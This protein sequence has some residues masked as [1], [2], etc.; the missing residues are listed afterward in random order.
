MSHIEE[1]RSLGRPQM[2]ERAASLFQKQ[3]EKGLGEFDNALHAGDAAE[4][5]RAAHALKSAALS[6]GGRRFAAVAGDC[7]QAARK[8]NLET[9]G[10]LATRL[11]P[12]FTSLCQGLAEITADGARAA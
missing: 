1:L 3:A 10:S 2:V 12:E 4:V 8:G 11:R 6:I 5:E 9:A 7:E